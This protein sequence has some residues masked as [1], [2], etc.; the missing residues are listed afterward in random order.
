ML[1]KL[2]RKYGKYAI[3]RL[4]LYI[5][6][7][8][9][10][11]YVLQMV[12]P[13]V[14]D[15]L[16]LDPYKILHGQ[17]FRII[18]W[19]FMP[20][21]RL[22]FFTVI[23]LFFIYSIGSTMER[24]WGDFRF[25]IYIFGGM[26][27]CVIGAFVLYAVEYYTHIFGS[28]AAGVYGIEQFS[29]LLSLYFTTYYINVSMIMAFAMSLPDAQVMLYFIIPIRMKW[30]AYIE[31]FFLVLDMVGGDALRR[32][33]I[34]L[35]V[36]NF[37]IFYFSGRK[38]RVRRNTP[39]RSGFAKAKS[40]N[41]GSASASSQNSD[42]RVTRETFANKVTRHKCAIC[43]RTESTNPELE[44]RFCSKCFGNYEYCSEHLFTHTHVK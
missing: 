33:V 12:A 35:S 28:S 11:G 34:I 14:L 9:I 37:I 27:F 39:Y 4:S 41:F 17:V 44:F 2:E 22:S 15:V 42:G 5:V 29:S 10:V 25:N 7:A 8:Y 3:P 18:T 21:Y 36:L 16:L 32:C 20:P 19:V 31:L 38:A 13:A 23:N 24:M 6:I 26:F 40:S 43:G 1:N 30:F